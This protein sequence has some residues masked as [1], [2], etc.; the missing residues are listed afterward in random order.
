MTATLPLFDSAALTAGVKLVLC[1]L[2][3]SVHVLSR[4]SDDGMVAEVAAHAA[5]CASLGL[6][7]SR[8]RSAQ[9]SASK[10]QFPLRLHEIRKSESSVAVCADRG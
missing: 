6:P 7:R 9:G 8:S 3:R 2:V 1:V 4:P 10:P 5:V